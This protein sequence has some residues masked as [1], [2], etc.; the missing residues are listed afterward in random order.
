M[1][2]STIDLSKAVSPLLAIFFALLFGGAA[3]Y[4]LGFNPLAAYA[5]LAKG[6]V[7]SIKAVT[8]TIVKAVPLIFT[9]LGFA[10]AKRCGM[11]NI[12]AEGQLYMGGLFATAVGVYWDFLPPGIHLLAALAAGVVGGGMW[13][14]LAGW[15][16]V[17]FGASEIITTI[18]LNYIASLF[19]SFLVTGPMKEPKGEFPQSSQIAHTAQLP[20]ILPGTRLHLGF[21]VALLALAFFYYFLWKTASGY[22][23]RVVG[24][25]PEAARYA[26]MN[27]AKSSLL[28]MFMAGGFSGLA[29]ATEILGVQFRLFQNF[30]PGYGF[31]G[32]AVALLGRNTPIG[33]FLSGLLFGMLRAG[34]NMMQMLAKVPVSV[35]SIMQAFVILF[36]VGRSFFETRKS[37]VNI[38]E[39]ESESDLEAEVGEGDRV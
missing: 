4:L 32:I 5:S 21:I 1:R 15:F 11:I 30:S 2:K 8:E 16:K 26:G 14:A 12:G 28:A 38:L 33:I 37:R 23:M 22:E 35:I 34:A 10:V 24:M 13:G 9:G 20:R 7:G 27:T 31:D 19:I 3:I 39:S 36:V 6:S 25:N 17:R 29:G 18:M